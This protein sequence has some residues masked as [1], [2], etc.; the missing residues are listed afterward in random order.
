MYCIG[1]HRIA[2]QNITAHKCPCNKGSTNKMISSSRGTAIRGIKR[3]R[4]PQKLCISQQNGGKILQGQ[5]NVNVPRGY[6]QMEGYDCSFE[7][8]FVHRRHFTTHASE[9]GIHVVVNGKNVDG[10][11]AGAD[12]GPSVSTNA[13]PLEG[14]TTQSHGKVS[15][16]SISEFANKLKGKGDDKLDDL[17]AREITK[18]IDTLAHSIHKDDLGK[19]DCNR[20]GELSWTLLK[21]VLAEDGLFDPNVVEENLEGISIEKD[22]RLLDHTICHNVSFGT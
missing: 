13:A 11:S 17:T 14:T 12:V 4:I 19:A 10:A 6:F 3:T 20:R 2:F 21:K 1:L 5:V 18:A 22:P 7:L 9:E 15:L 16:E 8:P